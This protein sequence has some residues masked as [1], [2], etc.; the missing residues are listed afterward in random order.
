MGH[1]YKDKDNIIYLR[2]SRTLKYSMYA[3]YLG[4]KLLNH[5]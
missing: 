2:H 3:V 1:L 5:W 4:E